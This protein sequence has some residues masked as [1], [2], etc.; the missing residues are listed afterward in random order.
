MKKV[1]ATR[2]Y[3]HAG[4]NVH[5]GDVFETEYADDLIRSGLAVAHE[6]EGTKLF[7]KRKKEKNVD[8]S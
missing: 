4:K 7:T 5:P 3:E 2:T 6:A 8:K 1:K